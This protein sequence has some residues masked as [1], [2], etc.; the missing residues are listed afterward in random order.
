MT[1]I[2][3]DTREKDGKRRKIITTITKSTSLKPIY[4]KL[5]AGDFLVGNLLIERCTINDFIGKIRSK[6]LWSQLEKLVYYCK[7]NDLKPVI[8]IEGENW[9]YYRKKGF[10]TNHRNGVVNSISLKWD[11]AVN[12]TT[13]VKETVKYLEKQVIDDPGDKYRSMR[14]KIP[15]SKPLKNWQQQVLEGFKKIGPATAKALLVEGGTPATVLL[16]MLHG[17]QYTDERGLPSHWSKIYRDKLRGL[18]EE[19][20]FTPYKEKKE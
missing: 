7:D 6:R 16:M 20:L 15:L 12:Y 1:N 9:N 5:M 4:K 2:I 10:T 18:N 3:V 11:V 8:L 17:G 19:V 13:S 14:D